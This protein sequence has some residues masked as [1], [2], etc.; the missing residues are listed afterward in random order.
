MLDYCWDK[1]CIY[2]C[3]LFVGLKSALSGWSLDRKSR[4][5]YDIPLYIITLQYLSGNIGF[6]FQFPT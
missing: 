5:H 2:F 4:M 1:P 3:F 6:L